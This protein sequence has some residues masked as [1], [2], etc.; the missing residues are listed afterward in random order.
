V[1]VNFLRLIP[2]DP[3]WEPDEVPA[4]RALAVLG[5]LAPATEVLELKRFEGVVFVDA[6]ANLEQVKCPYCSAVLQWDWLGEEM[7]TVHLAGIAVP[8]DL[9][10]TT[11]CCRRRASLNDLRYHWPA[12]FAR[13]ELSAM[14]PGRGFLRE[15]ERA[16]VEAAVGHPLRQI[17]AHY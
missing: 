11:P 12:G 16:Q 14:S 3:F 8:E 4:R 2:T 6:G 15:T 17:W 7:D 13:F 9:C 5:K 1:S 10:V